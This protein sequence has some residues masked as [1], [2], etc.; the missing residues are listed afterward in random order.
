VVHCLWFDHGRL[1]A[2]PYNDDG[3]APSHPWHHQAMNAGG[4]YETPLSR[5]PDESVGSVPPSP[6]R[7]GDRGEP[8]ASQGTATLSTPFQP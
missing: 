3:E 1:V 4:W 6:T 5:L 8:V 2:V 7:T